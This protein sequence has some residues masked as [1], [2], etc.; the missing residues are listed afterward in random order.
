MTL[1]F[2]NRKGFTLVELIIVILLISL[3]AVASLKAF[4]VLAGRSSEALIQSRTL[5]LAQLYLDEILAARFDE[6]TGNGGVPPYTGC[7]ITDDG[8]SRSA[9]D[10]V[11][12]YNAISNEPPALINQEL[13][14]V[15]NGYRVTV[16]VS[17]DNSVGVNTAGAKR[18]DLTITA[19]DGS[20][21]RF[22][23]YRGNF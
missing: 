22:T 21:S 5:D 4:S 15:Y 12:D 17:C 9:Y 8:E 19:V 2:R 11:D 6:Q 20:V 13:A 1:Y 23:A 3:A 10:D 14:S 7:R 16:R 18:I